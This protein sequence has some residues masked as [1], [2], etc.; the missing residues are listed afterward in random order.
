MNP[1][2]EKLI[3]LQKIDSEIARLN[4]EIASLPKRVQVIEAQLA[5]ARSRVEKAKAAIKADEQA[6]RGHESDIQTQR[7][8]VGKY[9]DQSSSVKTNDQYRALMQEIEFAEKAIRTSEDKVLDIMVDIEAKQEDV[10]R[11]EAD[12]KAETAEIEK[13]KEEARAKTAEDEAALR[14]LHA[15]RDELRRHID[16]STL[17]HYERVSKSRGTGIAEA[18][19]QR[20]MACQVMLRPQIFNDVM[21]GSGVQV[22]D[23]CTRLL[24]YVPENEAP[25]DDKVKASAR[26]GGP[27]ERAWVYLEDVGQNG[28]FAALV[29]SKGS[30]TMRTFDAATGKALEKVIEKGR[31]YKEAFSAQLAHGRHLWVDNQPNLEQDCKEELPF[32]V[33]Q[34][35]QR[36][37]PD[38]AANT[39]ES[40]QS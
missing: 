40:T 29:N 39:T 17:Y 6:R 25:V 18:R 26:A 21:T 5:D 35:L 9:R 7:D 11:A 10:K 3:D 22:C 14:E 38:R 32:D 19:G 24:Y 34:D 27:I 12:L 31:T 8:K 16:E 30:C 33:L 20:C 15:R 13:E 1:D 36:Q 2:L 28:A 4:A 23:S 37:I